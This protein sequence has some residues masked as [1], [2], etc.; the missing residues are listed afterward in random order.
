MV[1]NLPTYTSL[2][3]AAQR[4]QVSAETLTRAVESGML[5]A[6]QI[7]GEI[8]VA[9]EDVAVVAA[10]MQVT[11]EPD[12]KVSISEAARKLQINSGI[13]WWWYKH[14]WLSE[15]GRGPNRII[16]VSYRQA[17]AL[18]NLRERQGK[19][20]HRLIPKQSESALT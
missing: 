18:A 1:L 14:G 3:E 5:R 2:V 20:G 13:V 8:A 17:Q 10:Q 7:N 16:Y 12:D 4:Y 19:R 15:L 6:V 11:N 9:D